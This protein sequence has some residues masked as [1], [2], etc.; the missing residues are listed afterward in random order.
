MPDAVMTKFERSVLTQIKPMKFFAVLE[1]FA[2]MENIYCVVHGRIRGQAKGYL[3][4]EEQLRSLHTVKVQIR[5]MNEYPGFSQGYT[6]PPPFNQGQDQGAISITIDN[7]HLYLTICKNVRKRSGSGVFKNCD[8]Y[9][10]HFIDGE[11]TEP[12]NL[13]PNINGR[14][15]WESQPSISADGK[16]LYFASMRPTNVVLM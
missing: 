13:G 3:N 1:S 11:W 10:S 8:I 9:V 4:I 15:S 5:K 14:Y 2:L 16:T 7:K 6:M 12:E